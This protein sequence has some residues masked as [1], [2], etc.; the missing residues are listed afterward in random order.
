MPGLLV[1]EWLSRRGGS[2]N[3]LEE[4][5]RVFPDA[6]ITALWDDAPERFAAGRVTETWFARTPLRRSKA[7]ALPLMP[8]TWRHLGPR[9]AEWVLCSS[10]LFAHHARFSGSARDVPKLVYAHTPARYIWTPELDARGDSRLARRASRPL[11]AL[12]RKRAQEAV[13]VAVNSSFVAARVAESWE[14]ESIVIYPPVDVARFAED[15]RT[16]LTRG[17]E[18]V[19]AALPADFVLGAS[20]FVPYK[21]LDIAIEAGAAAGVPVVIAGEGPDEARLQALADEHPGLVTFVHHPS[22]ALLGQLYRKAIALVFP[23]VEDFGIM[24]VEAMAAGTPVIA[25]AV[26]GAAESVMEGVTGTLL[27]SFDRTSLEDAVGLAA[28]LDSARCTARAWEFDSAVFDAR[29]RGWVGEYTSYEPPSESSGV[30]PEPCVGG[31]E[32]E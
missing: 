5:S 6:P 12:D 14:R 27:R 9:D 31:R 25:N 21:R 10:H 8:T 15:T 28:G 1:H 32:N 4:L 30:V 17:E 26:G 16:L 20:R 24:P 7:L 3:V 2:E 13:S 11:R 29:I 19:L 23:A 22:S 18:E